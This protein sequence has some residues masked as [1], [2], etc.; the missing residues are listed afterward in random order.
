MLTEK[1]ISDILVCVAGVLNGE[2]GFTV[3]MCDQIMLK[4]FLQLL[5][6]YKN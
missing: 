5:I 3:A 4:S 6:E 2:T 1:N